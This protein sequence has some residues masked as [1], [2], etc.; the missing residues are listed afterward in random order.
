MQRVIISGAFAALAY[1][2]AAG[3]VTR[4]DD[5]LSFVDQSWDEVCEG[6]DWTIKWS[7]GNGKTTSVKVKGADNWSA[8]IGGMYCPP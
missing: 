1:R 2:A 7:K 3:V 5:D 6:S 8:S 4:G